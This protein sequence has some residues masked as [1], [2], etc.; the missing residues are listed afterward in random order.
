VSPLIRLRTEGQSGGLYSAGGNIFGPYVELELFP[1]SE[2]N[3]RL[4]NQRSVS[5]GDGT[6]MTGLGV[7]ATYVNPSLFVRA[8]PDLSFKVY[9]SSHSGVGYVHAMA[10]ARVVLPRIQAE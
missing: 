1:T 5:G 7:T 4:D 10:V 6:G 9:V 8:T 2:L 3:S